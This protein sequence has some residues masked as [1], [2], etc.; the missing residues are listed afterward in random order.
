M[1]CGDDKLRSYRPNGPLPAPGNMP[2]GSAMEKIQA[3]QQL[4]VGVD[5]NTL[6][7][8]ARDPGSHV[9]NGIRSRSRERDRTGDSRG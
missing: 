4:V 1:E 3:K 8:S 2:E 5:E 7:L 9:I 6:Q